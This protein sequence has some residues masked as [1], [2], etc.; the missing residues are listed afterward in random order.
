MADEVEPVVLGIQKRFRDLSVSVRDE[1]AIRYIVKQLRLKRHLDEILADHYLV[2]H[3][4]A[5]GRAQLLQNPSVIKA[6]EEEI[7][8]QFAGY[9]SDTSPD[10][11]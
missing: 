3:T 5:V 2:T 8:K 9:R 4:T 1:R 10:A 11:G 7:Q 6:I